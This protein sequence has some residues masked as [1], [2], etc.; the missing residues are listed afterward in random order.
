MDLHQ[1]NT[2]LCHKTKAKLNSGLSWITGIQ[3]LFF[4]NKTTE[5]GE[6]SE[7][8]DS[9]QGRALLTAGQMLHA[10]GSTV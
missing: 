10:Q 7:K 2:R 5:G 1:L 8:C 9:L 4:V 3:L 6:V